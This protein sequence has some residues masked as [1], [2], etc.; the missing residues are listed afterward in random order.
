MAMM[1]MVMLF[2]I[3]LE[4]ICSGFVSYY[5][6]VIILKRLKLYIE[7][8]KSSMKWDGPIS[9]YILMGIYIFYLLQD[10]FELSPSLF[11]LV[12]LSGSIVQLIL[13]IYG[14]N[15]IGRYG[16]NHNKAWLPLVLIVVLMVLPS[17]ALFLLTCIGFL[18]M[19]TNLLKA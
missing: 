11:A 15:R 10:H 14:I 5:L 12:A 4:S 8:S 13:A 18:C 19:T 9:G 3:L 7:P 6:G 2:S 16:R 1:P 17:I